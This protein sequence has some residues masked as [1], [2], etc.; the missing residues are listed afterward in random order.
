MARWPVLPR[1][2]ERD[3]VLS[4]LRGSHSRSVMLRGPS[5]VGKT[6]LGAH[7]SQALR[8]DGRTVVPVVGLAELAEIPLGALAPV[9]ASAGRVDLESVSDRVQALVAVVGENP[10]KFVLIVDDAPLLDAVSAGV[11][12]QLVRVF[13]VTA[14]L[15]AR[16]SHEVSGPLARLL[17]ENLIDIV[18]LDGLS[19]EHSQSI[20]QQY[21]GGS[22]RPESLR[23][24]FE[25]SRGN[26]LMLRELTFAAARAGGIHSGDFGV[27]VSVAALPKHVR[28]TISER[29]LQLSDDERRLAQLIAIAQP[30]PHAA[31]R[32]DE[33]DVLARLTTEGVVE[34]TG[35]DSLPSVRLA[36]PLF[37]EALVVELSRAER[38]E[39]IREVASRLTP[40]GD[41][42]LR[43]TATVLLTSTDATITNDELDWAA[44]YAHAAGDHTVA[45]ALAERAQVAARRFAPELV[46]ASAL[47]ALAESQRSSQV[48]ESVFGL[49]SGDEQRAI[50]LV[51]WGQHV[52]Y[53]LAQPA[54]AVE[55]VTAKL[56]EL[57][58]QAQAVVR[59][60]LAKWQLITGD[61][62]VLSG[63]ADP[64]SA[65]GGLAAVNAGLTA[66]MIATMSG[67][68]NQAFQIIG[69]T[70]PLTEAFRFEAPYA[71]ALLDLSEFIALVASADIARAGDFAAQRRL[72]RFADSAGVWS[73]ALAIIRLHDGK[74]TEASALAALAVDQ[75]KWRDF[76]GLLG[77]ATALHATIEAQRGNPNIAYRLLSEI[78][79]EYAGDA[80]VILQRAECEA[81]LLAAEGRP[82]DGAHMII[83][84]VTE[85]INLGHF[86]LSALTLTVAL[87]LDQAA[88]AR[89][90]C[91]VLTQLSTSPLIALI[92]EWGEAA[93]GR[94]VVRLCELAPSL[95]SA[96]VAA[97]AV[98]GLLAGARSAAK[99]DRREL[100]RKATLLARRLAADMDH[101]P[102]ERDVEELTEREWTIARA[103]AGRKRSREI[104]QQLGLSVRTVDNHLARIYRKLGVTGRVELE[105]VLT[106]L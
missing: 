15:T 58:A 50:A 102:A 46:L 87:R 63:V 11:L 83:A 10:T 56:G 2:S 14:L 75:L 65:D 89:E 103:A 3:A 8:A 30:I 95:A 48:F 104:G 92:R 27:E 7:I 41:Q 100:E 98:D 81:F 44:N 67:N 12:Y 54:Q 105:Q 39:I 85:G 43:F 91:D 37:A 53:R 5:G 1:E 36:H 82:E 6:T 16:D 13:G 47:S 76:T 31:I 96:G 61:A 72:D 40:M 35:D 90:Q 17:H 29:L 78:A 80:K 62:T 71:D 79:P 66:A 49:A 28:A 94:D 32:G 52:V 74:L 97:L 23:A 68:P 57:D 84:A 38:T 20:L 101:R 33:M 93:A 19:L 51:R 34:D 25:A 73:Y 21:F 64:V 42:Q 106:E 26:P 60:E 22:L 70:R 77:T 4:I 18:D 9:L 55:R 86:L 59:P 69:Q 24:L 45:A 99:A 88:A